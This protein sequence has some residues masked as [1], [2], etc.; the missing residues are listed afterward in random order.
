MHHDQIDQHI[1]R[2]KNKKSNTIDFLNQLEGR[3][4][5][6]IFFRNFESTNFAGVVIN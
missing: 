1:H 4:C 3:L 2:T 6:R 5:L